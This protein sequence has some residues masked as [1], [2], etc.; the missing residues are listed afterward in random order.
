LWT[1]EKLNNWPLAIKVRY[2]LKEGRDNTPGFS[3]VFEAVVDLK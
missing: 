3:E 1:G 2:T